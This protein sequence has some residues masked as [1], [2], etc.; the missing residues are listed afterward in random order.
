MFTTEERE[1]FS[2]QKELILA[3]LSQ[4]PQTNTAL[5]HLEIG[6]AHV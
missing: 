3:A 4:G 6:R 5:N 1:R 2:N